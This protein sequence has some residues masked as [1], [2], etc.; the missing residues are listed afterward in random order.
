MANPLPVAIAVPPTEAEYLEEQ[1]RRLPIQFKRRALNYIQDSTVVPVLDATIWIAIDSRM[2]GNIQRSRK[3]ALRAANMRMA[4]RE[5]QRCLPLLS[6]VFQGC[7]HVAL[8]Q[9]IHRVN[10]KLYFTRPTPQP[11][12]ETPKNTGI[13]TMF[14]S[15]NATIAPEPRLERPIYLFA[16]PQDAI[17]S[18]IR[19]LSI[20]LF[21]ND[22]KGKAHW[23]GV[24][25]D[26]CKYTGILTKDKRM[27]VGL[28][29][30]GY[31]DK[32][33]RINWYSENKCTV[34]LFAGLPT[35]TQKTL[36]KQLKG[37]TPLQYLDNKERKAMYEFPWY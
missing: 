13:V 33:V 35:S 24:L 1:W 6:V 15:W 3:A 20:S 10:K 26:L 25:G 9:F 18:N 8:R 7:I 28:I 37:V 17:N 29:T 14:S 27:P 32:S 4:C 16:S 23:L 2:I 19:Y 11:A 30:N 31:I 34:T 5:F 12:S 36:T 21:Y 22:I